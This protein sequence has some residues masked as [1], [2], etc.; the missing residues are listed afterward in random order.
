MDEKVKER[1]EKLRAQLPAPQKCSK[2]PNPLFDYMAS[3]DTEPHTI[4]GK[5]VCIHC[6]YDA[7]G[8]EIEKHPI[9]GG[10]L[11]IDEFSRDSPTF[12]RRK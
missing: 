12:I 11:M 6:F 2:C 1:I 4:D 8:E 10:F 5:P 9:G 3:S 7:L